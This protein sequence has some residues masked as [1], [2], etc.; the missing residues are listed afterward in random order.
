MIKKEISSNSKL[1]VFIFGVLVIC[2]VVG[3]Y[4]VA[5]Q[6]PTQAPPAG[7]VA[8]PLNT[9]I[10]AQAKEGALVLGNNSAVTT[11]L[12]VKYGNVGIGTTTPTQKLDVAGYVKGTGL[13]IG[14]DCRTA[15]PGGGGGGG[16]PGIGD[17][18]VLY[19]TRNSYTGNLGGR[20]GAN[21]KC[22]ADT[23]ALCSTQGKALICDSSLAVKDY[24]TQES[25]NQELPWKATDGTRIALIATDWWDLIDGKT[26][27]LP[28]NAGLG[29]YWTGCDMW[30]ATTT[31]WQCVNW[32]YGEPAAPPR[33][34]RGG[35]DGTLASSGNYMGC[36]TLLPVLCFCQH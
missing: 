22:A 1:V 9:S 12:I 5:W 20:S 7:N 36:D 13:C 4:V 14:N 6:E 2:F 31:S 32:T 15:W 16:S 10:N 25:L 23:P 35:Y 27:N 26:T 18:Y 19:T 17:F 8:P 28:P 24:L 3:Y 34:I 33:G 29:F 21:D 11:G 30:G